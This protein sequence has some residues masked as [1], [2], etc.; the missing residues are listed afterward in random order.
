MNARLALTL[1]PHP[2]EMPTSYLSRLAARNYC[3]DV[4]SFCLDVGLDFAALTNG[5]AGAVQSLNRLVGLPSHSFS[6]RTV[7]KTSSMKYLLGAE[8]LNTEVLVRGEIRFCPACIV[9][10]LHVRKDP[11]NAIHQMHWQ[12]INIRQCYRHHQPL[13]SFRPPTIGS[14][15]FDVTRFIREH[16]NYIHEL[17]RAACT[18]VLTDPMD[19]YLSRRIYGRSL[20]SWCNQF[21]IPALIKAAEAAG[22]LLGHGRDVR[23]SSLSKNQR[24]DAMTTGFLVLH[25]GPKRVQEALAEF[26]FRTP[27]RGGNQPHPSNGELQRLLGS[28]CKMRPD[29]EPLRAIVREFFFANYPYPAGSTVMGERLDCRRV[30]SLR[31]ICRELQTRLRVVEDIL[32]EHGAGVRDEKGH[33]KQTAVLTRELVAE[34]KLKRANIL[35]EVQAAECLGATFS[36]FKQLYAAG[37]L[38]PQSGQTKRQRKVF[39]REELDRFL[40]QMVG[41]APRFTSVPP[42]MATLERVTHKVKCSV[43]DIVRFILD[44]KLKAAGILSSTLELRHL[45]ICTDELRGAFNAA[46]VNGYTLTEAGV[47]VGIG[48]AT[49]RA[50]IEKDLLRTCY[51]KHSQTRVTHELV[52]VESL[53]VFRKI[54]C[55]LGMLEREHGFQW[56]GKSHKLKRH[57]VVPIISGKGLSH[58]YRRSDMDRL[59]S[60]FFE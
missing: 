18:E 47:I 56:S 44:G 16:L 59:P 38:V 6:G 41:D 32:I 27:S 23:A 36:M 29:L 11:W 33:F 51:L 43:P 2:A 58:I 7:I 26:N 28:N 19:I 54:Y 57:D 17:A 55:S 60:D 48:T 25:D 31:G 24:R 50:L 1:P 15:R 42:N 13:Q 49:V 39:R 12:L 5:D 35:N 34:L 20:K 10:A 52:T 40:K 30:F 37:I 22:V 46:P 8:N 9:S 3:E 21:T 14:Y 53:G 45:L 4:G